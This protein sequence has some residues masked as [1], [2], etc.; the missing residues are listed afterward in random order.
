MQQV[1]RERGERG[2]LMAVLRQGFAVPQEV[3]YP[4]LN[5]EYLKYN[6][7]LG[8]KHYQSHH[9]GQLLCRSTPNNLYEPVSPTKPGAPHNLSRN[10][11][12]SRRERGARK[13]R[14]PGGPAHMHT[15]RSRTGGR[16]WVRVAS[17]A[18]PGATTQMRA[19]VRGGGVL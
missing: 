1:W 15:G 19:A 7:Y 13:R 4:T 14:R 12:G 16:V 6:E 11:Y 3:D 2:V 9:A 10:E 8:A 18:V 17:R 5:S